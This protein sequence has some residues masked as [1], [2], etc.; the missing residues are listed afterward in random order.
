[1]PLLILILIFFSVSPEQASE[2]NLKIE[3]ELRKLFIGT[4]LHLDRCSI[5]L[6]NTLILFVIQ[7][8]KCNVNISLSRAFRPFFRQ[9]PVYLNLKKYELLFFHT[10]KIGL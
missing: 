7:Y 6:T 5:F 2:K 3:Q 10:I 9:K 1:M 8:F 4:F